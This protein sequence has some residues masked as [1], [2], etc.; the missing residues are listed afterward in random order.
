MAKERLNPD[1]IQEIAQAVVRGYEPLELP[2]LKQIS[3]AFPIVG[4]VGTYMVERGYI[5]RIPNTQ[6]ANAM[7]HLMAFKNFHNVLVDLA[8]GRFGQQTFVPCHIVSSAG[9][10]DMA[11]LLYEYLEML[12]EEMKRERGLVGKTLKRKY[13][14]KDRAPI[15]LVKEALLA[16]GTL[17]HGGASLDEWGLKEESVKSEADSVFCD[18]SLTRK[19]LAHLRRASELGRE[20]FNRVAQETEQKDRYPQ[21]VLDTAIE[22]WSP[23]TEFQ[24]GCLMRGSPTLIFGKGLR[25]EGDRAIIKA[26]LDGQT[27]HETRDISIKVEI[28]KESV[29]SLWRLVPPRQ[30]AQKENNGFV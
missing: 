30:T 15:E 28:L 8:T 21:L 12:P 10:E 20:Y 27:T 24:F 11:Y 7:Y 16:D 3:W 18:S 5:D 19:Y 25:I 2:A 4:R 17:R 1:E 26:Q 13:F 6:E 9:V 14:F 22:S 29:D 23:D